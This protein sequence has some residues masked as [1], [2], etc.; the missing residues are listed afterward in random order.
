MSI[1]DVKLSDIEDL[2]VQV[3]HLV[4]QLNRIAE[5]TPN[6]ERIVIRLEQASALF[7]QSI[8]HGLNKLEK[9][10]FD[11]DYEKIEKDLANVIHHQVITIIQSMEKIQRHHKSL[12]D[13]HKKTDSLI[14]VSAKL[15]DAVDQKIQV[16]DKNVQQIPKFNRDMTLFAVGGGMV[17]GMIALYLLSFLV[18]LP[19]PYFAT[20]EQSVVLQMVQDDVIR[21]ESNSNDTITVRVDYDTLT[22]K[23]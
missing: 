19:K 22:N 3:E 15:V 9:A 10:L 1:K 21:I 8:K 6:S 5:L 23:I 17:I 11:L 2:M 12:E 14:K 16:L 20:A 4:I 7:D 18:W 13:M